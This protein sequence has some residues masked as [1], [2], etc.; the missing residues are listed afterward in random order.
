MTDLTQY[1]LQF[2]REHDYIVRRAH[3]KFDPKIERL[4]NKIQDLE[5]RG[6]AR[7]D[8]FLK[9]GA[10]HAYR[11]ADKLERRMNRHQARLARYDR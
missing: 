2:S 11:R 10:R 5:D 6:A 9:I 7:E 8:R 3:N 4:G 1:T